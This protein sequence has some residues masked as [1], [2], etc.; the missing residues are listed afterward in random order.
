[1]K[2]LVIGGTRYFGKRLVHYLINEGHE[3]WVMSRGQV[4]D[5]FGAKVHRLKADRSSKAEMT[6]ALGDLQFDAV[7]D[8]VCMNAQQALIATELFA[9]KNIRLSGE[10]F[11]RV[12]DPPRSKNK[13]DTI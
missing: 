12:A 8:Q 1:M 2:V 3:V 7:V 13:L 11:E 10:T 9:E 5:D 4:E 6:Q